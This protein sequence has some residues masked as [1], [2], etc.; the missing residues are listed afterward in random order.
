[1]T[2][3][4]YSYDWAEP[5]E[6]SGGPLAS[7]ILLATSLCSGLALIAAGGWAWFFYWLGGR[8]VARSSRPDAHPLPLRGAVRR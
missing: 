1:M 2:P 3:V 8:S 7:L 6:W 4:V 5:D